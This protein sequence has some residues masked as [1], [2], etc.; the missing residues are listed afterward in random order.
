M[1]ILVKGVNKTVGRSF[2]DR[3]FVVYVFIREFRKVFN[4]PTTIKNE[5]LVQKRREQIILAAIKLFSEKGFHKTT[6]RDLSKECRISH[7]NIYDYIG[8]KE[9]ILHLI[10]EFMA[11]LAENMLNGII[12]SDASPI[13]KLQQMIR[14][15]FNLMFQ[16]ADVILL[17]YQESH[18]LDKNL[19][20]KL[21][22]RERNHISKFEFVLRECI[23]RGQ[24]RKCNVRIVSN[25]I[26]MMIDGWVLKRWDLKGYS[27][28]LEME[29]H[30]VSLLF[31][32]LI[33]QKDTAV[34][35]PENFSKTNL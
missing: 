32:G 31:D 34:E 17:I 28:Q 16:W 24:L 9:H 11:D 2:K 23:E 20:R 15:E 29:R 6:L 35:N 3:P 13:E 25:L 7:G 19:M 27:T 33:K 14:G 5:K 8:N 18:I 10:H 1:G 22:G 4:V 26:K 21:L 30:I 12:N